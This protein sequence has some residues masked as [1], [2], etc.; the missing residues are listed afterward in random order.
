[1]KKIKTQMK[2]FATQHLEKVRTTFFDR[3]VKMSEELTQQN[4][5]SPPSSNPGE[6]GGSTQEGRDDSDRYEQRVAS[7]Q[8]F[9]HE[10]ARWS[11]GAQECLS[12]ML[13]VQDLDTIPSVTVERILR[14]CAATSTQ[15]DRLMVML[16]NHNR[17]YLHAVRAAVE[18]ELD[19]V[20]E[21]QRR[22]QAQLAAIDSQID[23]CPNDHALFENLQ[24]R[25]IQNTFNT[26]VFDQY[27][28]RVQN[29]IHRLQAQKEKLKLAI[30]TGSYDSETDD[31]DEEEGNTEENTEANKENE[32][33]EQLTRTGAMR[34]DRD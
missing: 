20:F 13:Y 16:T 6:S 7:V 21:E 31:S 23:D 17:A 14:D 4:V 9:A 29:N 11:L 27:A 28:D 33:E 3:T 8:C 1:M 18:Q 5:P 15:L 12:H 25:H 24:T 34:R 26:R 32:P 19:G 2:S 10:A 22:L 30:E